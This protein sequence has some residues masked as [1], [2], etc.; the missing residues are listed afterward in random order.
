MLEGALVRLRVP[1]IADL[2]RNHRWINDREVMRYLVMRYQASM[3]AEE[4][5][6]RERASVMPSYSNVMFAIETN[7]GRHIGNTGLH[8]GSPEDRA[9]DVGIMIGEKDCWGRGYG[10]DALR[11]LVRFGFEDMN[12]NRIALD[13]YAFNARAIRS[14]EKVG[15][16]HEARRRQDIY[17]YGDYHDVLTMSILRPEWERA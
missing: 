8:N 5:W 17:R 3:A 2:E 12:L 9:A 14:Y 1:D 15:F 11:T 16:V 13:V 7:D 6:M 10:T 4:A